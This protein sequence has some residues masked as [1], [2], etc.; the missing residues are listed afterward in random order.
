[1]TKEKK[2]MAKNK[3]VNPADQESV[4]DV[5]LGSVDAAALAALGFEEVDPMKG[6][7]EVFNAGQEGFEKGVTKLGIFKGTKLCV[8]TK[9]K[10]H[11]WKAH[12]NPELAAKGKVVRK[13]YIFQVMTAG[14]EILKKYYGI[15]HAGTLG[16]LLRRVT[17]GQPLAITYTGLGEPF[18]IGQAKPHTFKVLG[19]GLELSVSDLDDIEESDD[20][21]LTDAELAG[22][23]RM[24]E[25][26]Q[27]GAS[28]QAS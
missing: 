23:A 16:A 17:V 25:G 10:K 21:E 20:R 13:L 5:N 8:S 12:P 19:K 28:A 9:E 14:G 7:D 1:M 24:R 2:Q 18:K 11:N 6:L 22:L 27:G 3:T 26:A 4:A 15:W